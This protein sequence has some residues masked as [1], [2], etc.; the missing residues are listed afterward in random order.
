MFTI[1][2]LKLFPAKRPESNRPSPALQEF[3]FIDNMKYNRLKKPRKYTQ[4]DGII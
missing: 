2:F 3:T 1:A 4:N